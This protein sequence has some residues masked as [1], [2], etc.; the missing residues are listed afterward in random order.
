V[1]EQLLDTVPRPLEGLRALDVGCGAARWCRLLD[2]RGCDTTG[3][4]LQQEL[5]ERNR[6]AHPGIHFERV[7]LQD[8]RPPERFNLVS[9]VTVLQHLPFEEQAKAVGRLRELLNPGGYALL[10]E[11]VRDQDPHVFSNSVAGWRA[12]MEG[13][14]FE[15]LRLRRYDYSPAL[16]LRRRMIEQVRSKGKRGGAAPEAPDAFMAPSSHGERSRLGRLGGSVNAAV[17]V[18][19]ALVDVPVETRLIERQPPLPSIHCGFLFAVADPQ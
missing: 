12:L 3:I 18:A 8:Y 17:H 7:P 15:L 1:Y 9:S 5:I 13:A 11:N 6:S 10:L 2:S 16:R 19:A 4:D 14:G